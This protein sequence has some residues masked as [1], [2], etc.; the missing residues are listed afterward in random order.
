[1]HYRYLLTRVRGR[2]ER[3]RATD[4]SVC[5]VRVRV[6]VCTSVQNVVAHDNN[7]TRCPLWNTSALADDDQQHQQQQQQP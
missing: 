5:V 4:R 3:H 2:W 7:L 6:R 1:M